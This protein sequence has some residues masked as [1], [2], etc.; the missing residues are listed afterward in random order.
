VG[1]RLK[2]IRPDVVEEMGEG[3]LT[4]EPKDSEGQ[5]TDGGHGRLTMNQVPKSKQQQQ[6]INNK[7]KILQRGEIM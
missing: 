2:D 6:H 5:V 1:G 7:N 4:A 3:V